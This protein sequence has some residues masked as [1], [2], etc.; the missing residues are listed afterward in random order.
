MKGRVGKRWNG[1][2][3][4]GDLGGWGEIQHGN[5]IFHF[6]HIILRDSGG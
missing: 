3:F 2:C 6:G 4:E 1:R 5:I